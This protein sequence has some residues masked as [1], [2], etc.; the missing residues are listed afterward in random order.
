MSTPSAMTTED[1]EDI[2]T[3]VLC[4][5]EQSGASAR[6]LVRESVERWK[7]DAVADD[8]ELVVAELVA[9]AVCHARAE[10]FR[11]TVRRLDDATVRIAVTD[12]SR[13]LPTLR[14]PSPD[15]MRGRGL[16]IVG[17]LSRHWGVELLPWGKRVF[18]DLAVSDEVC[19]P[20]WEGPRSMPVDFPG[21][22]MT[23][24]VQLP[25][26][27]LD[28]GVPAEQARTGDPTLMSVVLIKLREFDGDA[29]LALR[30]DLVRLAENVCAWDLEQPGCAPK[31]RVVISA[32]AVLQEQITRLTDHVVQVMAATTTRPDDVFSAANAALGEAY[33]QLPAL[34]QV[35]TPGATQ[36]LARLV[37]ALYAAHDRVA[38]E[39]W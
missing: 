20:G 23:A 26:R 34:A 35:K 1:G 8:A 36:Q 22:V 21:S 28:R 11:V 10:M 25:T 3:A 5:V 38:R 9:N 13:I 12:R 39:E 18:A 7:L 24:P 37:P 29:A 6:H 31:P 17:A 15:D 33:R 4:R 30:D 19:P 27:T 2:R 16:G 14:T 32:H